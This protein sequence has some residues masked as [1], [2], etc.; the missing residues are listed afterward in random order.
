MD[1]FLAKHRGFCYGVKRAIDLAIK[2]LE[3]AEPVYTLGPIIHNPQ[4]VRHLKD[5]GIEVADTVEEI[6]KGTIIIRSHGVGPDIFAKAKEKQLTI[7]DAT[8]P[9]VKKAQQAASRLTQNGYQ[10]VVVGERNHPEVQSILEWTHNKALVIENSAEARNIAF[11]P[12]LGVVAQTTFSAGEFNTIIDILE[13]KCDELNVERTICMAT[14]Q[15]QQAAIQLAGEIDVMVVVGGRNSANTSRLAEICESAGCK[16][17]HVETAEELRPEW[18][19][20]VKKAGITAGASTPDWI[21]EEVNNQMTQFQNDSQFEQLEQQLQ[22]S[23]TITLEPGSIIKGKIIGVRREEVFVDIGYKSEGIIPLSELAYPTPEQASEVVAEG[24][25]INVYV[26]NADS[27]DGTIKLSK[28]QADKLTAWKKL[29]TSMAE[30]TPLTGKVVDAVKGGLLVAV[31][32]IRGF[33]PASQME[34]K[35]VEDLSSYVGQ[36]ITLLPLEIDPSKQKAVFSRKRLLL[37]EREKL[38]G[39]LVAKLTPGQIVSGTVRRLTNFGAFVDI[40]GI[41][42]LIHISDLSWQRVKSPQEVVNVGDEVKVVVLKVD[43]ATKKISLSLKQATRD[44]WLDVADQLLEGTVIT[45]TVSKI[46]KFG[47]FVEIAPGV[48]GL[49]HL[50]EL[51]DR[52][53]ANA[54]EVVKTGQSVSVK[55]LSINRESKKISLSM[56]KAQQDKEKAEYQTYL[57]NRPD[58]NKIT[59]GD[60]F[61]HLFTSRED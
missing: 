30:M 45:G 48:E 39:E 19:H 38:A 15:R 49:V 46:A 41:D 52:R 27:T 35:F 23:D 43:P 37:E 25:I 31:E 1:I 40:G 32:G 13:T 9:H 44:P 57:T 12:R 10:V 2:S 34:L 53:V 5:K 61:G 26:I 55:I 54:E 56:A 4:M 33:V 8:C 14:D 20:G 16:A 11:F 28:I 29:E 22:E 18:F 36:T 6:A 42:G 51:S 7:V 59:L 21:I 3:N 58:K 17:Y 47:V 60:K 24:D 50:S